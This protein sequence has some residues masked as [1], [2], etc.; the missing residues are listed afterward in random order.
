[1]EQSNMNKDLRELAPV[2]KEVA[3]EMQEDAVARFLAQGGSVQELKGRKNPKP[4]SAKGKSNSGMKLRADPTARFPSK[5][6]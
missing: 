4:V 2:P 5:S 6:Y 3:R 1:M